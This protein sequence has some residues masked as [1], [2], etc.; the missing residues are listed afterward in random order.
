MCLVYRVFSCTLMVAMLVSL[1]KG[2]VAML[3]FPT[4]PGGIKLYSYANVSF[5]FS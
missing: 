4:N 5:C 3:V 2:T 1:N